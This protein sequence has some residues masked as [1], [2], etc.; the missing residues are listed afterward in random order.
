MWGTGRELGFSQLATVL[1][2]SGTQHGRARYTIRSV[3]SGSSHKTWAATHVQKPFHRD[4]G[5]PGVGQ[6]ENMMMASIGFCV[7]VRTAVDP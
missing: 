5:D 6:R 2:D 4:T 7:W 1:L 3:S